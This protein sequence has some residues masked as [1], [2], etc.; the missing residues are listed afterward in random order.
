MYIL[1]N[2]DLYHK[3]AES[4]RI[5]TK[6]GLKYFKKSMISATGPSCEKCEVLLESM[7]LHAFVLQVMLPVQKNNLQHLMCDY[8]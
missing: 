2:I 4:L 6:Y 8:H 1:T 3:C 7:R 5:Q